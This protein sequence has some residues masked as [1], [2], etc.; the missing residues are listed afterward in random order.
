VSRESLPVSFST[1]ILSIASSAVLALGLEKNPHTGKLEKD[2]DVARF[3]IDMLTMLKEKTKNNLT[4]EE[5]KFLDSLLSDLQ[6]KFVSTQ[7][8][9]SGELKK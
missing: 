6:I 2:L 8:E 3:N 5:Q 7:G 9:K 1:L 4:Q